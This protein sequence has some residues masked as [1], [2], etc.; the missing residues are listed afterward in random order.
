ML[1]W[2]HYSG[3]WVLLSLTKLGIMINCTVY[4]VVNN[5]PIVR[6]YFKEQGRSQAFSN[7]RAKLI[8]VTDILQLYK[9][10]K[11]GCFSINALYD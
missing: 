11:C 10:H 8:H 6:I 2:S 3:F 5:I 1:C 9:I 4:I 7:G